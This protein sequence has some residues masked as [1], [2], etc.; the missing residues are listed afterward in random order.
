[1]PDGVPWSEAAK[2]L[3]R[4]LTRIEPGSTANLEIDATE[5]ALLGQDFES[6]AQF[7]SPVAS[8]AGVTPPTVPVVLDGGKCVTATSN[9]APGKIAFEVRNAGKHFCECYWPL[10]NIRFLHL[11]FVFRANLKF[12]S[13]SPRVRYWNFKF[14]SCTGNDFPLI[15]KFASFARWNRDGSA[16]R[17]P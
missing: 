17:W 6:D 16:S 7:F 8:G 14:K 11:P 10:A 5:G 9:I 1:M 4:A 13:V 15:P 3:V 2:G 12:Q